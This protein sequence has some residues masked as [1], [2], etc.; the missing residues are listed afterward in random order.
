MRGRLAPWNTR[1][2]QKAK[3]KRLFLLLS[4]GSVFLWPVQHGGG[5]IVKQAESFP[6]LGSVFQFQ[7]VAKLHQHIKNEFLLLIGHS[8]HC[9]FYGIKQG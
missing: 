5:S 1:V 6:P 4:A 3:N 7:R 8:T 9:L 2:I